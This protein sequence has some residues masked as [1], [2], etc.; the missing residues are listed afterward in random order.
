MPSYLQEKSADASSNNGEPERLD[1]IYF[2][3]LARNPKMTART[4]VAIIGNPGTK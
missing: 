3:I 4:A 1:Q 2:H